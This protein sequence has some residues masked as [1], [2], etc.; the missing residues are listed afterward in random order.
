MVVDGAVNGDILLAY[1]EQ[2][3]APTLSAGDIVVMDN[4]SSHK[5]TGVREMIEARGATSIRSS[6]P[7]PNS[8]P[9]YENLPLAPSPNCGMHSASCSSASRPKN[10][11]IT[12]P[13]PDMFHSTG[14]RSSG[15]EC[16]NQR[17]LSYPAA[18]HG[19]GAG[20][21]CKFGL[22]NR[23]LSVAR[24]ALLIGVVAPHRPP[25]PLWDGLDDLDA[26]VLHG[27]RPPC[28]W[29]TQFCRR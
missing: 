7:S 4:L 22:P 1:V 21:R 14:I 24:G 15:G 27:A 18:F 17:P 10:A 13:T 20:C 23:I 2:V 16:P 9:C 12:S 28:C 6:G 5:V 11:S 25:P 8:K 19:V 29:K 3:L 26:A